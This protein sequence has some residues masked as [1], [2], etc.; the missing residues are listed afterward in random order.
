MKGETMCATATLLMHGRSQ[1]VVLPEE[2]RFA[3]TQVHVTKIGN[4]LILEP[5][6]SGAFKAQPDGSVCDPAARDDWYA[7]LPMPANGTVLE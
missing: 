2:F 5:F 1:A 6:E 4:Q 7:Q 3:G